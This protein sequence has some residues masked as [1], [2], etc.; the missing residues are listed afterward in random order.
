MDKLDS[1]TPQ[2]VATQVIKPYGTY[3]RRLFDAAPDHKVAQA[4][5]FQTTNGRSG[6]TASFAIPGDE[7]CIICGSDMPY[8]IRQSTERVGH[9]W[10]I[11][12][13]FVKGIMFGEF[14][15]ER[16]PKHHNG[17]PYIEI[18]CRID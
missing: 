15:M 8:L 13:A 11:G 12:Q 3:R 7:I 4:R 18:G 17:F 5:E 6:I 10:I 1:V 14:F 16:G 2:G 9:Y